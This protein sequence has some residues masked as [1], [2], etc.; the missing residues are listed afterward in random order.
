MQPCCYESTDMRHNQK[1]VLLKTTFKETV[2]SDEDALLLQR[3]HPRV[4]CH[5]MGRVKV[6]T[7]PENHDLS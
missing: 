4:L 7:V 1:Y 2:V 3:F 5:Y 6:C